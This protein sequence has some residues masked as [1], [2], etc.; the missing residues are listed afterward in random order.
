MNYVAVV[1][2]LAILFLLGTVFLV[3]PTL[4]SRI[5]FGRTVAEDF[6]TSR[7]G[8][9]ILRRYRLA[10]LVLIALL[11]GGFLVL[12]PFNGAM[13]VVLV[14]YV[15]VAS[16]I[17]VLAYRSTR[18][19]AVPIPLVRT[20]SLVVNR[21][22]EVVHLAALLPL[23]ITSLI[24]ALAWSRIPA[25]YPMH[26]SGLGTPTEWAHRSIATVFGPIAFGVVLVIGLW[27]LLRYATPGTGRIRWILPCVAWYAAVLNAITALLPSRH[28]PTVQPVLLFYTAPAIILLICGIAIAS[29]L[30]HP[31][32]ASEGDGTPDNHW[33]GGIF[34]SNPLDPA[35]F[36]QKRMG[37]GWA[38][39]FGRPGS[40]FIVVGIWLFVMAAVAL[41]WFAHR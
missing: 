18:P 12:G 21:R 1:S 41:S 17:W 14:A 37:I 11:L 29:H 25:T 22:I 30:H 4:R 3:A 7:D 35:L 19:H 31:H 39:N 20:G 24:L 27:A 5:V 38:L 9:R 13:L 40:W 10:Q 6:V 33:I 16:T 36:V 15:A 26:W 23:A 32:V 28:D 2:G 34:Y 8:R